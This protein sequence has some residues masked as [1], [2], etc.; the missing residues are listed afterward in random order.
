MEI[1]KF[2]LGIVIVGLGFISVYS[3]ASYNVY[4]TEIN[5]IFGVIG[6]I[7]TMVGSIILY[8][9]WISKPVELFPSPRNILKRK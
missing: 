1:F 9:G 3:V 8:K 5:I 7:L 6:F 2:L 4:Y